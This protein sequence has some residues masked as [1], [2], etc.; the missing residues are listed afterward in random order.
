MRRKGCKIEGCP[1]VTLAISPPVLIATWWI[2][3][4]LPALTVG[5]AVLAYGFTS[6]EFISSDSGLELQG[7]SAGDHADAQ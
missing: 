6:I 3:G 5:A 4:V 7:Y 1:A 2:Y